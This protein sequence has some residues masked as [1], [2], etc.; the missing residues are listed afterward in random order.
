MG[1]RG[2]VFGGVGGGDGGGGEGWGEFFSLF[3]SF[4]LVS[5]FRGWGWGVCG[6]GGW[7]LMRGIGT[8]LCF[9]AAGAV[10]EVA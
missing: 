7:W 4:S 3:L 10:E 5:L 6:D 9:S 2:G 1:F 8:G